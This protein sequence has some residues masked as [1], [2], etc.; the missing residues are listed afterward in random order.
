MFLH[1]WTSFFWIANEDDRMKYQKSDFA[2]V[3]SHPVPEVTKYAHKFR[4]FP[5]WLKSDTHMTDGWSPRW[6]V[7]KKHRALPAAK[8]TRIRDTS[9]IT[10]KPEGIDQCSGSGKEAHTAQMQNV[11]TLMHTQSESL[12][13]AMNITS[14][15]AGIR[16]QHVIALRVTNSKLR[17]RNLWKTDHPLSSIC[18]KQYIRNQPLSTWKQYIMNQPLSDQPLS[19]TY[20]MTQTC[21][22]I[23][24]RARWAVSLAFF[25]TNCHRWST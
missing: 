24:R 20:S 2:T 19:I 5:L 14:M 22:E 25:L 12:Q 16:R 11:R 1:K 13:S 6:I 3:S 15:Q 17:I 4:E 7:W 18:W 23:S 10:A 21:R 9:G 8:L